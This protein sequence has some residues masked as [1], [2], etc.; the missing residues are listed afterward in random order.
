[1]RVAVFLSLFLATLCL[2]A[3]ASADVTIPVT[4]T[5]TPPST[6]NVD[7]VS[8]HADGVLGSFVSGG[9]TS[10]LSGTIDIEIKALD[11]TAVAPIEVK[12]TGGTLNGT[13]V[14]FTSPGPSGGQIF[15]DATGMSGTSSTPTPPSSVTLSTP[16]PNFS[17]TFAT[18]EHQVI[19][20]NGSAT[21]SS[22]DALAGAI[23]S[24]PDTRNLSTA[25]LSLVD[26]TTP[27]NSTIQVTDLGGGLFRVDLTIPFNT[28]TL[29]YSNADTSG[30]GNVYLNQAGTIFATGQF[31]GVAAPE[32]ATLAL[33]ALGGLF[34]TGGLLRRRRI[35][36]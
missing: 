5:L 17:G 8:V 16:L 9:S 7:S 24:L 3:V 36:G 14:H 21:V 32:P 30:L 12:F 10:N 2:S 1:M 33:L 11:L 28:D 23:L 22:N 35:G 6:T 26:S 20:N 34:S 15:F 18:G 4:L 25:P 31:Q 29:L 27:G 19:V 13:D